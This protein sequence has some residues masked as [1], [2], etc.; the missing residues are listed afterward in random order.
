V[1]ALAELQQHLGYEFGDSGLLRLALTHP[2]VAQE[3]G[4]QTPH[5]QRLE[6]LGDAVLG[7]VLAEALYQRYPDFKEGTLTKTRARLVNHRTLAE[8]G[9]GLRL[10]HYLALSRSDASQGGRDRASTLA[11]AFEAVLGAL[12]LDGGF[13]AARA[14]ILQQF[15]QELEEV[16]K[17]GASDNPKGELQERIQAWSATGPAYHVLNIAGPDHDRLFEC[18]VLHDGRELGRGSGRSKQ[19]AET[20][21][22]LQALLHLE[23]P[24][25][26]TP[27]DPPPA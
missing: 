16:E 17:Q 20:E 1:S 12:L 27:T 11:D 7:L 23:E 4:P 22:A 24:A 18:A 14:F 19:A 15:S 13:P 6:F 21:A 5:N 3:A 25:P 2:S 9:R 26:P 10:G 8:K